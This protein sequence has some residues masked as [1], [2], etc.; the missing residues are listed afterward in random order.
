MAVDAT[1]IL[2]AAVTGITGVLGGLLGY[3]AARQ[4]GKVELERIKLERDRLAREMDEPHLQ[5]R[6]GVYHNFLDSAH[7]W[8]Q[9]QYIEPFTEDEANSY[10]TWA[11][12]FEHHLNAVSLFG[13]AAAYEAA[14][15]LA[16]A[17]EVSMGEEYAGEHERRFLTTYQETIEAMRPDTA[18]ANILKTKHETVKNW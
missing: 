15:K 7:R 4:Q 18:P 16:K 10:F 17:I 5:H 9:A 3:Q 6:Q 14:Q 1:P 12:Q 2:T 11:R 8:H 13:T